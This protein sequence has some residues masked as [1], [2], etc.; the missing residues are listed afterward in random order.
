MAFCHGYDFIWIGNNGLTLVYL[1]NCFIIPSSCN[2][3]FKLFMIVTA[4][5]T[6]SVLLTSCVPYFFHV[7]LILTSVE[8]NNTVH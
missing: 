4:L 7:L 3:F 1:Q 2:V 5:I 8:Y 6:R